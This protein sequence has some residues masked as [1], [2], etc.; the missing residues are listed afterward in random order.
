MTVF[1]YALRRGLFQPA[2]MIVN[3]ILPIG[4]VLVSNTGAF[5]TN[6]DARGY[7]MLAMFMLFG[8]FL[9]SNSIQADRL[10][11]VLVRILAGPLTFRR[12]LVQNFFAGLTPMTVLSVIIGGIGMVRHGWGIAFALAVV[13]VYVLLSA[14]SIGL[15]FVWS[16]LFKNRE[17]STIAF[18]LILTFMAFLG[19]I[20]LPIQ[21]LP[22]AIRLVGA[23]FPAH[24]S[25]RGLEE[26]LRYGITPQFWLSMLAL[27]AFT[28][29]FI[30]YGSKRRLV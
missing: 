17:A 10:D 2:S 18:S 13:L 22:P 11:G 23:I 19:G 6:P 9:M 15:S 21:N 16:C 1:K 27:A 26:L 20:M 25:A 7:F 3:S 28:A 4:F 30:L 5:G 12:Y 14:T 8:A 29:A 24:W